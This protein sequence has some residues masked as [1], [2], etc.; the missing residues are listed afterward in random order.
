MA[1]D[2]KTVS[3]P[4]TRS[5]F[6]KSIDLQ[7]KNSQPYSCSNPFALAQRQMNSCLV[8]E[9]YNLTADYVKILAQLTLKRL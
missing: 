7:C 2:E 1:N 4:Y 5:C 9:A 3:I 6:Y 8:S